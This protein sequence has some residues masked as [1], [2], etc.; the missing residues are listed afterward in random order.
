[1]KSVLSNQVKKLGL[2]GG[3]EETKEA[4]VSTDPAAAAGMT[5]EEYEEYQKQIVEE[6]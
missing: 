3:G 6:K 1:M 5:R 4:T 2:G